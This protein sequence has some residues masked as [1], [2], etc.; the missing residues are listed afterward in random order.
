MWPVRSGDSRAGGCRTQ[1]PVHPQHRQHGEHRA[2]WR[3]HRRAILVSALSS[4]GQCR[5]RRHLEPGRGRRVQDAGPALRRTDI[6]LPPARHSQWVGHAAA[7][8]SPQRHADSRATELGGADPAARKAALRHDGEVHAQ[9][10]EYEAARRVHERDVLGPAE[11]GQDRPDS[12]ALERKPRPQGGGERGGYGDR[13]S[14][15]T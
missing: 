13:D 5:S 3:N 15:R 14:A 8:D 6:W 10:V 9:G 1:R 11:R 7:N 2:D 4:V 12:R